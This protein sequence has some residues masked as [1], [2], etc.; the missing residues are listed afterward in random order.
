MLLMIYRGK[1][2]NV[3][4]WQVPP[5][6]W[7]KIGL[8]KT[9]ILL[10]PRQRA[11]LPCD[12]TANYEN[13]A[14]SCW[15]QLYSFAV[16]N[17]SA[18]FPLFQGYYQ[19]FGRVA[20]HVCRRSCGWQPCQHARILDTWSHQTVAWRHHIVTWHH[21]TVAWR[22]HIVAWRHRI[23]TAVVFPLNNAMIWLA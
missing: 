21:Q 18:N 3:R 12:L 20:T 23:V 11:A 16:I 13:F 9:K 6:P 22:H 2:S 4:R 5:T 10:I 19:Y 14:H 8:R 15:V 1:M 7:E 17:R